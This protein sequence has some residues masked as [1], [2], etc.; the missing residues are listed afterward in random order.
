M[1]ARC[2][3]CPNLHHQKGVDDDNRASNSAALQFQQ[4]RSRER[5]SSFDSHGYGWNGC[6]GTFAKSPAHS[7]RSLWLL[8]QYE[9]S[10]TFSLIITSRLFSSSDSSECTKLHHTPSRVRHFRSGFYLGIIL[11]SAT[12]RYRGQGDP[13]RHPWP[14]CWLIHIRR[15]STTANGKERKGC[16]HPRAGRYNSQTSSA[17]TAQRRFFC[18]FR[19]IFPLPDTGRSRWRLTETGYIERDGMKCQ[20]SGSILHF[21]YT[22]SANNPP[23]PGPPSSPNSLVCPSP[24]TSPGKARLCPTTPP[25]SSCVGNQ[26]S[27][28]PISDRRTLPPPARLASAA[29]PPAAD[30][31]SSS[32]KSGRFCGSRR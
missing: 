6:A 9:R 27:T 22:P 29:F 28:P 14:S 32:G 3:R 13:R 5:G 1:T 11:V 7:A 8:S 26:H 19:L 31:P 15:S 30:S 25:P 4:M 21:S 10:H 20:G 18:L 12:W 24:I 2:N 23:T 17:P 16:W